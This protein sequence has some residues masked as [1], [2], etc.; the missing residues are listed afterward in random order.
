MSD[1]TLDLLARVQA[2]ERSAIDELLRRHLPGLRGYVR[3]HGGRL[4]PTKED[5]SDLVQ[6]VCREVLEHMDRFQYPSDAGFRH[7]LFVTAMRKIKKRYRYWFADKRDVAR[8]QAVVAGPD[9][10]APDVLEGYATFCTPSR[11]LEAREEVARIEGAFDQL[12]ED[13]RQV[14]VLARLVGLSRGEIGEEMGRTEGAVRTL[15]SRAQARLA[16]ILTE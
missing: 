10:S 15:L 16:E 2:G 12:P 8:E 13:Y 6:S 4:L 9:P 14:I 7:W 3:L 11:V 1:A 5:H